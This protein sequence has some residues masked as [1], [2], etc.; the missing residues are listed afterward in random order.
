MAP[1]GV[2]FLD[3]REL[4]LGDVRWQMVGEGGLLGLRIPRGGR[5]VLIPDGG[6][7]KTLATSYPGP[8]INAPYLC[9]AKGYDSLWDMLPHQSG[10]L[11]LVTE[12]SA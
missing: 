12:T 10:A 9:C 4:V 7:E 5:P 6:D 8:I 1:V 11:P 3:E 2:I